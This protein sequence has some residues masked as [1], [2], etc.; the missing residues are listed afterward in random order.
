M[1]RSACLFD[2]LSE[3]NQQVSRSFAISF[4]IRGFFTL[5][6]EV[7]DVALLVFG[8]WYSYSCFFFPEMPKCSSPVASHTNPSLHRSQG[9]HNPAKRNHEVVASGYS[10]I[11]GQLFDGVA[12]LRFRHVAG[13]GSGEDFRD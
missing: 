12:A 9:T 3:G 11:V 8:Y 5:K 2:L 10:V 4:G 1:A 13:W 6:K 7:E